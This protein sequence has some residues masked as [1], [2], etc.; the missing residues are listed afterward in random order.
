MDLKAE[1][2]IADAPY[3]AVYSYAPLI[4]TSIHGNMRV[5]YRNPQ[6]S[7]L[8]QIHIIL[9]LIPNLYYVLH[10]TFFFTR[11]SWNCLFRNVGSPTL[12][13]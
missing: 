8:F 11:K 10:T 6:I 2:L 13:S 4:L 9:Y 7:L 12:S 5:L 1:F 3:F